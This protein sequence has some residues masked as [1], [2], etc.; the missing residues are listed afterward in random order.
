MPSSFTESRNLRITA[1]PV[2]PERWVRGSYAPIACLGC[3][4]ADMEKRLD[5]QFIDDVEPGLGPCRVMGFELPGGRRFS[6]CQYT[7]AELRPLLEVSCLRD[8]HFASDLEDVLESLDMDFSDIAHDK[9][10]YCIV[11]EIRL[12]PHALWR[13]D[14]NGVRTLMSVNPLIIR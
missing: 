10:G 12:I 11:P 7:K 9:S 14:D 13:Q 3:S 6:L 2:S 4:A 5:V 8:E 1:K